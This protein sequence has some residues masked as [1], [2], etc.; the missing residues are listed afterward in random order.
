MMMMLGCCDLVVELPEW[1]IDF[2]DS[3][4]RS[5]TGIEGKMK[6]RACAVMTDASAS[7]GEAHGWARG[8]RNLMLPASMW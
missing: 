8:D 1:V 5:R 2:D 6:A 7:E 3:G 4:Q